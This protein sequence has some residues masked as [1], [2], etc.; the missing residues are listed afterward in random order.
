MPTM[1]HAR[2]VVASTCSKD[3]TR[4]A[5]DLLRLAGDADV[6]AERRSIAPPSTGT[7]VIRPAPT[8]PIEIALVLDVCLRLL[9]S[10][11]FS[12][13]QLRPPQFSPADLALASKHKLV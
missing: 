9:A 8:G 3:L 10:A 6:R 13:P 2:E 1:H 12:C 11:R 7:T 4:R 5:F